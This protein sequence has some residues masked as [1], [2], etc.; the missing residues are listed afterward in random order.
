MD[1]SKKPEVIPSVSLGGQI[2][3]LKVT[4]TTLERFSSI[5]K[6]N[7]M[8][9]DDVLQRYDMMV[10]L[11]WLM[12]ADGRPDVTREKVRAWL[13]ELPVFNAMQL[14]AQAVGDAVAY[15]FPAPSEETAPAE[16]EAADPTEK[17]T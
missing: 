14:V 6:C 8:E 2:W 17:D 4:H 5:A 13:D 9:F 1:S 12:M 3:F 11:L 16:D 10:L 15:S 7:L